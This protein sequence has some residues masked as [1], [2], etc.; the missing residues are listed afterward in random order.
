ML[1]ITVTP[2]RL[3]T[4]NVNS[5]KARQFRLIDWLDRAQPDIAFLQETKLGNTDFDAL[6][7]D[8]L[9]RRDYRYAHVG[10]GRW[11][12]V[13]ILSRVGL[14][15]VAV[16]LGPNAGPLAEEAR[17]V[18]ATCGGIR[19]WSIYVPNGRTIDDPMYQAKLT[20][21]D[22]LAGEV[23]TAAPKGPF[24]VA[25]DFNI[26]PAD[27]DVWDPEV[28]IGATHVTAPERS[29]LERLKELGLVDL[30]RQRWPADVPVF[31]YW[32]YR[33][34]AFHQ[35]LGMRIDL[36]YGTPD[37]A[38]RLAAAYTDRA[39][40]K[41]KDPSDHAPV[42]VDLDEARDG[43]IGPVVPPPSLKGSSTKGPRPTRRSSAASG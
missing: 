35:D 18:G 5:A 11:N 4:W 2:V 33:A 30:V 26:A 42:I 29:A 1:P 8:D 32:D 23:A 36:L 14:D 38:A 19:V 31:S 3:A 22:A 27:I 28:F 39:A 40:R 7:A 12:G 43:D 15:D 41:G 10:Q 37:L 34:G 20:W 21:L 13:A 6:F 25:G 16:G 17:A 9:F 24:V